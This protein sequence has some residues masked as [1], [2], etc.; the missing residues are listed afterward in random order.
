[1]DYCNSLLYGVPDYVLGRLQK[2]QNSAAKVITMSRKPEHDR[3]ILA[4]L[5]WLPVKQ[6]VEFKILLN[7]WKALNDKAPPYIKE[8]LTPRQ[9]PRCVQT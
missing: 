1:M 7:T 8:L 9:P 5:H 3:P 4:A 6:R 2:V